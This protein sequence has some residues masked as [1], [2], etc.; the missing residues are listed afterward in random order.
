MILVC[1][2]IEKCVCLIGKGPMTGFRDRQPPPLQSWGGA[3][4]RVRSWKD[5]SERGHFLFS[6]MEVLD[7]G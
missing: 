3:W 7:V 4:K 5:T 2:L 6:F 1:V